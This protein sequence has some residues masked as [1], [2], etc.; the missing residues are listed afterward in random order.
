MCVLLCS[1]LNGVQGVHG[2]HGGAGGAALGRLLE[3]V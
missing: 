3:T 1:L 2:V